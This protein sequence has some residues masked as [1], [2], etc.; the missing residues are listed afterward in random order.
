MSFLKEKYWDLYAGI[1]LFLFSIVLF[2]GGMTVKTLEVSTFGSGFFPK[3]MAV[4]L[5][6]TCVPIILGGADKAKADDSGAEHAAP[7][8]WQGVLMTFALMAAYAGLIS[9]LGFMITTAVYL[10]LQM[11]ILAGSHNRRLGLFA[12]VSVVSAVSI[13]Y[14]FVKVFNLMLP[15]GFLG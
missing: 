6:V 7:K 14:T 8:R 11:N 5:A 12:V 3:I 13:N 10:F 1:F 4:L 2:Y 15:A 9:T